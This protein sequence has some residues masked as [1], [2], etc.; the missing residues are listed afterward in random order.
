MECLPTPQVTPPFLVPK[1]WLC[2][3]KLGLASP[4]EVEGASKLCSL[5]EVVLIMVR[6]MLP[7]SDACTMLAKDTEAK[8]KPKLCYHAKLQ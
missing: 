1:L 2:R 4:L 6:S 3:C 5:R 7:V 8:K